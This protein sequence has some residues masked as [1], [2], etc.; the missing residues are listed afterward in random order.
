M[1]SKNTGSNK[2]TAITKLNVEKRL[3]FNADHD[4]SEAEKGETVVPLY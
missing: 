1:G 3:K 2:F 4:L